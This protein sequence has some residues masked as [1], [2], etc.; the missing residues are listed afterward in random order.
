MILAFTLIPLLLLF[1]LYTFSLTF[2]AFLITI[3]SRKIREVYHME[4]TENILFAYMIIYLS[5]VI[6][7]FFVFG[8]IGYTFTLIISS[9]TM[10]FVIY[11]FRNLSVWGITGGIACGKSTVSKIIK[12]VFNIPII[13]ADQLAREVVEPGKFAYSRIV[14]L[15]GKGILN[16]DK[17]LNRQKLG[18]IIFKS[19]AKRIMLNLITHPSINLL[20]AKRVLSEYRKGNNQIAL[21]V[22]LLFE[23]KI[24]PFFCYP[25]ITIFLTDEDLQKKRLIE[26]N[27]F[28]EEEAI[29]RMKSQMPIAEKIRQSH[30]N[31]CNDTTEEVLR[32]NIFQKLA[33]FLNSF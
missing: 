5:N 26:R 31:I 10:M 11:Y 32:V 21:E 33:I 14:S 22:P 27:G 16:E 18:E 20:M 24:L 17:T 23:T 8:E 7:C 30:V 1:T 29:R 19:K 9:S 13:D 15:F 25:I 6:V 4:R 3:N 12:E 2:L 28:T